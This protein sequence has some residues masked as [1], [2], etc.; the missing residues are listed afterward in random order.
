MCCPAFQRAGAAAAH[1]PRS[2]AAPL[3]R[4]CGGASCVLAHNQKRCAAACCC[5]LCRTISRDSSSQ[6]KRKSSTQS[7][8]S[9]LFA[10]RKPAGKQRRSLCPMINSQASADGK[11]G[12]LLLLVALPC[13]QPHAAAPCV[14]WLH[15]GLSLSTAAASCQVRALLCPAAGCWLYAPAPPPCACWLPPDACVPGFQLS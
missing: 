4:R 7:E 2:T 8:L 6:S 13:A 12:M 15:A 10:A 14:C 11:V 3:A 5:L 1:Q 9:F